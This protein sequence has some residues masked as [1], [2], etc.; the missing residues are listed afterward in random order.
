MKP[1]SP[2]P[3]FIHTTFSVAHT[4]LHYRRRRVCM[5]TTIKVNAKGKRREEDGRG[6]GE[7]TWQVRFKTATKAS[8]WV[9]CCG[10][11]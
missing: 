10:C 9:C 1:F 3:M 5:G 6:R 8:V 7:R 4:N 11:G 2:L